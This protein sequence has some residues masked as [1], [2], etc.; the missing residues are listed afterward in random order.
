MYR[1]VPSI[2]AKVNW[3]FHYTQ[4]LS[5]PSFT[6]GPKYAD[7]EFL[8]DLLVFYVVFVGLWF[9]TGFAQILS[10]GRANK[11]VGIALRCTKYRIHTFHFV[12]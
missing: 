1:Q 2:T 7:Q 3:A 9:Y 4:T 11:M 10:L 12:F 5:S 6:T 8:Q